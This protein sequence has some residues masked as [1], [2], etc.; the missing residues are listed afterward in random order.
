[1]HAASFSLSS[2]AGSPRMGIEHRGDVV[3]H[4]LLL[5]VVIMRLP[6][7]DA[8]LAPPDSAVCP[9]PV[10]AGMRGYSVEVSRR[11]LSVVVVPLPDPL[12]QPARVIAAAMATGSV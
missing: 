6:F 10:R 5:S 11:L 7:Y 4:G 9:A 2:R 1:M 8:T 12:P 3:R